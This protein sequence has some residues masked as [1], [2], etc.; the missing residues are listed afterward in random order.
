MTRH[1]DLTGGHLRPR[2]WT[3]V[4]LSPAPLARL[5]RVADVT[6]LATMDA[7]TGA[8]IAIIGSSSVVDDAFLTRAGANLKMVARRG[9]GYEKV[10]VSACTARGVLSVNTP[11]GPS[12][13]TAEHAVALLL[14]IA[15]NLQ[16]SVD[17]LRTGLPYTRADL[18]GREV[19]GS[20]LGVIG[21]GRIGRRVSRICASG[22]GM[23]VIVFEPYVADIPAYHEGITTTP[24][25]EG[26][27]AEAD[28]V[29]I[30]VPLTPDTR[31]LIGDRELRLM[32]TG[33][34]LINVSRGSIVDEAAL[35]G[36]LQA[37]HIAGAG[38][39]VFDPEPPSSD[40]PLLHMDNVVA[41]PHVASNTKEGLERMSD[42]VVDQIL[43]L[44]DGERPTFLIDPRAWGEHNA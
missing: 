35:I 6:T 33:A 3:E 23:R 31:H 13:S 41:T 24:N 29:S 39:D 32:K 1:P 20:T 14:A 37:G 27:L 26:L 2:V 10:D 17:R 36:A 43:Q 25:L 5:R 8:D 15:K 22:L 4:A 28:F 12:Q 30:H 38:L 42:G 44:L 19:R 18:Q 7:L 16:M 11:D 40:N 9:I 34:C 21:F